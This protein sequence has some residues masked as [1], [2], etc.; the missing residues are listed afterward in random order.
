MKLLLF[1]SDGHF[2]RQ[3]GTK[4]SG[5]DEY[6]FFNDI[7]FNKTD[8]TIY[9]QERF[10][11]CIYKYNLS[12]QLLGKTPTCDIN[13]N[14][15]LKTESGYWIYSCFKKN[16]SECYSLMLLDN[17]LSTIKKCFFPQEAFVNSTFSSTF[18]ESNDGRAFFIYPSS[19][20][21]Y[22]LVD[23][24]VVPF[25]KVDFGDK[26]IPYD[27][28]LKMNN[29][30]E[31]DKMVADKKYLGNISDFKI[32]NDSFYFTFSET[33]LNVAVNRYNCFYNYV[34]KQTSIYN[35]PFI[36]SMDFPISTQLLHASDDVLVYSMAL[37]VLTDDS[38][39]LL[40]EKFGTDIPF[41]SNPVLAILEL[42]Q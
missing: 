24:N 22:E 7:Q 30:E 21:V 10:R 23:D 5:P 1:K 27:R 15:F 35:N 31:Y 20:I 16:N 14:S 12:G 34:S 6:M 42:K 3:I 19:N 29:M 8:S 38:F 25:V 9:A 36:G 18:M 41:D 40:S 32:N 13:F 26:T 17:N 2:I 37:Q 28:I 39:K 4:G 33:G 11:N